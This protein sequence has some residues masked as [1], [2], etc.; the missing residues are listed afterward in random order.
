MLEL[1]SREVL[2]SKKLKCFLDVNRDSENSICSKLMH[3]LTLKQ[4]LNKS[5]YYDSS[6]LSSTSLMHHELNGSLRN[7]EYVS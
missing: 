4:A 1:R 3:V 6:A 7:F 2:N 5:S